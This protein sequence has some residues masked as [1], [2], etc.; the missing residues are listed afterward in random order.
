[1]PAR[2]HTCIEADVTLYKFGTLNAKKD[3]CPSQDSTSVLGRIQCWRRENRQSRA[4]QAATR[5]V[6]RG[7]SNASSSFHPRQLPNLDPIFLSNVRIDLHGN[8]AHIKPVASVLSRPGNPILFSSFC[9]VVIRLEPGT[10]QALENPATI[11]KRA[12]SSRECHASDS[13]RS[14]QTLLF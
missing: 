9:I 5:P 8:I 11:V 6:S 10:L 4:A 2:L 1:M 3:L 12:P 7:E 14:I 13:G